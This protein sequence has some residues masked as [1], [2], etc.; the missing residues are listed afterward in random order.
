LP[1]CP[2]ELTHRPKENIQL[3]T[4]YIL[5]PSDSQTRYVGR[6]KGHVRLTCHFNNFSSH[7]ALIPLVLSLSDLSFSRAL[8]LIIFLTCSLSSLQ[9]SLSLSYLPLGLS[10]IVMVVHQLS[11]FGTSWSCYGRTRS[12]GDAQPEPEVN[13]KISTIHLRPVSLL[14]WPTRT[15]LSFTPCPQRHNEDL[16]SFT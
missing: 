16:G 11:T 3:P 14:H 5:P 7:F 12:G 10:S 15:R 9:L 4:L 2:H 8:S 13:E 6:L 1:T